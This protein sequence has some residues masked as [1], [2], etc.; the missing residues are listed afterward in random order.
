[1]NILYTRVS[2]IDQKTDRQRVN[3]KDYSLIVEDYCS[4]GIEFFDREGGK[5]IK[6]LLDKGALKEL[7]V[8]TIDRLGR[9]VRDI[10]N[11][12][13]YF[14]SRGIGIHFVAQSL[15]TIDKD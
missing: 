12:I 14:T 3:E 15:H 2:T 5:K 4:G 1:M 6:M 10:L 13:H 11:T 8:W 7:S 9:N